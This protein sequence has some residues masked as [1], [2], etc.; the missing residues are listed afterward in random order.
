MIGSQL[1]D[2]LAA[3]CRGCLEK[4]ISSLD[5][6]E[7]LHI[8]SNPKFHHVCWSLPHDLILSQIS[9]IRVCHPVSWRS[10]LML[11][12][13]YTRLFQ[14][15]KAI[16]NSFP[17]VCYVLLISWFVWFLIQY[18]VNSRDYES[19]LNIVLFIPLVMHIKFTSKFLLDR[20]FE[21]L[22]LWIQE[23]IVQSQPPKSAVPISLNPAVTWSDHCTLKDV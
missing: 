6:W 2:C 3:W 9:P 18:F 7:T 19:A 12:P 21:I 17:H 1:T 20:N 10:V 4:L 13:I 5:T 16:Q 14:I 11:S 15:A 22:V 23:K 8:L